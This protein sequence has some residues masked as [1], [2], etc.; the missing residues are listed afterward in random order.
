[1]LELT[2]HGHLKASQSIVNKTIDWF[3][4]NYETKDTNLFKS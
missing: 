2:V 1:M 3:I 4:N